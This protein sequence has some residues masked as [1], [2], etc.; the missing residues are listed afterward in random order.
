MS[1]VPSD[2]YGR[3]LIFMTLLDFDDRRRME[4]P[5]NF[6]PPWTTLSA[7]LAGL[8]LPAS[9]LF[10]VSEAAAAEAQMEVVDWHVAVKGDDA[11]QAWPLAGTEPKI[12]SNDHTKTQ[13]RKEFD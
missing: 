12:R 11:R 13:R 8:L 6:R 7:I 2:F 9:S 5:G 4:R 1:A 3:N 10:A